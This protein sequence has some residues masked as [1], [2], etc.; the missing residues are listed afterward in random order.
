VALDRFDGVQ[1]QVLGLSVDSTDCLR[2]WAESLGGVTYPL[3]SDFWPHGQVAQMYGVLRKQGY[4]ERAL[5]IIDKQGI[6]RY[7]DVHDIDEQ[8]DNEVL[9]AE[10]AK[11]EPAGAAAWAVKQAAAESAIVAAEPVAPAAPQPTGERTVTMYCTPW[12]PG[13]RRARIYL[14]ERGIKYTEVDISKDR[15]AAARVRGWARGYETTPIF[16]I[17]GTIIVEFN[18]AKVEAA[19]GLS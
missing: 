18:V 6:V 7:V 16:D 19:L 13:C 10:L 1:T 3:L 12:C 2:A 8:P 9:F 5:F 11:L 15:A 14:Q 4:S 17:G